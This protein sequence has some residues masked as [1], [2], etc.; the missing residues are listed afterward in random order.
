[1][2]LGI[3][4]SLWFPLVQSGVGNIFLSVCKDLQENSGAIQSRGHN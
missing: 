1:M 4:K 3:T 2:S